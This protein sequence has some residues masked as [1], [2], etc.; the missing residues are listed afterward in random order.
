MSATPATLY[1]PGYVIALKYGACVP[2]AEGDEK[3]APAGA[4]KGILYFG[5]KRQEPRGLRGKLRCRPK[6]AAPAPA[7]RKPNQQT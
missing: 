4:R 3:R 7:R 5:T 1:E 6:R 2:P